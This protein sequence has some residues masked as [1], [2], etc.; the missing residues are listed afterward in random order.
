MLA[1]HL[2]AG[3]DVCFGEFAPCRGQAD[4]AGFDLDEAQELQGLGDGK[5][6]VD[7]HLQRTGDV[8]QVSFAGVGRGRECFQ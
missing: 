6:L 2:L 3:V 4:V 8:R 5:E 7:L 1:E